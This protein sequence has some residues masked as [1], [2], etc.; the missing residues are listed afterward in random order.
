MDNPQFIIQNKHK[1]ILYEQILVESETPE[2]NEEIKSP[3]SEPKL[4]IQKI[5]EYCIKDEEKIG[6]IHSGLSNDI[7]QYIFIVDNVNFYKLSVIDSS[8]TVYPSKL[9]FTELC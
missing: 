1:I 7:T 8:I 6:K 4:I 9:F 2:K 3:D 5:G